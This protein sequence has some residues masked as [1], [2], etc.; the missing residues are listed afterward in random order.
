MNRWAWLPS[1]IWLAL[2]AHSQTILSVSPDSA[3]QGEYL[4]VTV[5]GMNTMFRDVSGMYNLPYLTGNGKTSRSENVVFPDSNHINCHFQIPAAF[6]TGAYTMSF[7]MRQDIPPH[8]FRVVP[9]SGRTV[10]LGYGPRNGNQGQSAII[11][12]GIRNPLVDR[13]DPSKWATRLDSAQ[14]RLSPVECGFESDSSLAC[15]YN[16]D[17]QPPMVRGDF[18]VTYDGQPVWTFPGVFYAT[19]DARIR[20]GAVPVSVRA[21]GDVYGTRI[22]I[23]GGMIPEFL[24]YGIGIKAVLYRGT[25]SVSAERTGFDR[26]TTLTLGFRLPSD[27]A[28]GLWHLRLILSSQG[29]FQTRPDTVYRFG[30]VKVDAATVLPVFDGL[31]PDSAAA[32]TDAEV[33][34]DFRRADW[35]AAPPPSEFWLQRGGR[36]LN[37]IRIALDGANRLRAE[38][39]FGLGES[40][41]Y[42]HA[43]VVKGSDTL[44]FYNA[45]YLTPPG[46]KLKN[47]GPG[48]AFAGGSV[49]MRVEGSSTRFS[50]RSASDLFNAYPS[51]SLG[52]NPRL[53]ARNIRVVN[54]SL[55]FADFALPAGS[56]AL[57]SLQVDQAPPDKSLS[58]P[59]LMRIQSAGSAG[60]LGSLSP[61]SAMQ[62]DKWLLTATASGIDFL[63][64]GADLRAELVR[65]NV[66]LPVRDALAETAT[67]LS[68]KVE[69]PL[70]CPGG[71]Y[72]LVVHTSPTDSL[73][74]YSAFRV[75][76]KRELLDWSPR[77]ILPTVQKFRL[78]ARTRNMQLGASGPVNVF[79]T[80]DA[81]S[82]VV[83]G[84]GVTV[85]HP[86]SV[87]ADFDVA[88]SVVGAAWGLEVNNQVNHPGYT[89]IRLPNAVKKVSVIPTGLGRGE[90]AAPWVRL[91]ASADPRIELNL[92]KG[93]RVEL[94]VS[95]LDGRRI[96]RDL[97]ALPPGAFSLPMGEMAVTR[98]GLNFW[99]I[100]LDGTVL[101]QGIMPRLFSR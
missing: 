54:D 24:M 91:V 62:T 46:A 74:R 81:E 59:D 35:N 41:G 97:G 89:A 99:Q 38:F 9:A 33:I 50:V 30:V 98:A 57:L 27:A 67:L 84:T 21:P 31:S 12:A 47:A 70:D 73:I 43:F 53:P 20:L 94:F 10:F 1:A 34:A 92:P 65:E 75:K 5:T 71:Y 61:D 68:F 63:A 56:T 23:Q 69:V 100:R 2:P 87:E 82:R 32:A 26:D 37:P 88:G 11:R 14:K 25:D 90:E 66:S 36:K 83:W 40:V 45:L 44:S 72:D 93:G 85:I 15:G 4:P 48:S 49:R 39:S 17:G 51:V 96:R 16:F 19:T 13:P 64:S 77:Y 7:T 22:G 79:L 76:Y 86:D 95:G 80:I 3:E 18:S 58:L 55:L 6:D 28:A 8:P 42:W 52:P 78:G 101:A 60:L 29:F